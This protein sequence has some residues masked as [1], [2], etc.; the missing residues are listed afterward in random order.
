MLITQRVAAEALKKA[1]RLSIADLCIGIGYTGV[2]LSNGAGGTCFT[3]R[4]ELGLKCCG[5]IQGAG[6]LIGMPAA[7]AI[8]MAMSTNLA[9]ASIGV[10]TINAILNVG[11][12][13]GKDAV[14]EMDIRPSDTVGMVGYFYPVVKRIK[15]TVKKLYIFERHIT[16]ECLL[17]D[18]CENIYLPECD[19]VLITGV[20]FINK[21]IDHV[22]SLCKNAKEVVIM[23]AST[24]MAPDV[25]KDYGVTI[26][27]GSRVTDP[28][29]LL[30]VIAQGGGGLDVLNYTEKLCVRIAE[31]RQ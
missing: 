10:A 22:L 29:G 17:P 18:W 9:E 14:D 30:R 27:A 16:D 5:P 26:L 31:R 20:T 28:D 3:F 1:D 4:R 11:F 24:C 2:K 6:T 12:E 15:D 8:E 7:D 21:T 19:V 23:G 13:A 25:L